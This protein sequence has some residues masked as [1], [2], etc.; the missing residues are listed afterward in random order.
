MKTVLKNVTLLGIDCV[1]IDRLVQAAEIC[2][3]DFEFADIKLLTSLPSNSPHIVKIDAINSI[4]AYSEFCIHKLNSYVDTDFVLLIQYD[5]FIL[6]PKAWSDDFLNY[7]YIGAP[8]WTEKEKKFV[9]GN[10][11]FS[12]RSKKLLE[13][14]Q[15]DPNIPPIPHSE[16]EDT[17]ISIKLR[18]Y[19]ESV[20]IKFAPVEL[21]KQFSFES[22]EV[23]GVEWGS[24]FGFHGL[25]WTDISKWLEKHPEYIMENTLNNWAVKV[26]QEFAA[27]DASI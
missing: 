16:P 6:N 21:A 1:N 23:D 10:G 8:W 20:G 7:D 11:G 3:K 25:A 5:G 9:V 26:K 2:A 27:R 19:L 4:E 18:Q 13:V 14:L 24:Q 15:N 17:Y 12:F 22:N